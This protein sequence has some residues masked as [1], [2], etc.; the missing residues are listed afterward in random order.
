MK[1]HTRPHSPRQPSANCPRTLVERNWHLTAL[2]GPLLSQPLQP[3]SDYTLRKFLD[4]TTETVGCE[5][6]DAHWLKHTGEFLFMDWLMSSD[7]LLP[8]LR[9]PILR[10]ETGS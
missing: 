5:A 9:Q 10:L 3:S 6:K 4:P 2:I 7:Q 1:E 8:T